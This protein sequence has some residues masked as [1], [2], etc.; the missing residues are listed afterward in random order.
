ML[1]CYI[2]NCRYVSLHLDAGK[3]EEIGRLCKQI[4]DHG[5]VNYLSN[6]SETHFTAKLIHYVP[7]DVSLENV[8]LLASAQ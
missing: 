1:C 6:W 3:R 7:R 5:R 4:I 2:G 8:L